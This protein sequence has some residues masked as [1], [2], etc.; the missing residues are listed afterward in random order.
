M[1]NHKIGLA[2]L[3][4]GLSLTSY[5]QKF[6]V[7]SPNKNI[8]LQVDNKDTGLQYQVNYKGKAIVL[9]SN[10]GVTILGHPVLSNNFEVLSSAKKNVNEQWKPVWG[11][12]AVIQDQHEEI[13]IQLRQKN[14][15]Q[16]QLNLIFRVFN[17][18]VA[19]R[20]EFPKQPNLNYFILQS[21]ET[22]FNLTGNHQAFWIPADFDTNE[23]LHNKT[24]LREVDATKA[25]LAT[26]EMFSQSGDDPTGVQTP[27]M[28]KTDDGIYLNIHEAALANYPALQ[29]HVETATNSLHARLVPDAVGNKAYLHAPAQS[30]WRTLLISDKATDI[31][32]ST[33]IL[34]LNEPSKIT[35]T[36]WIKPMKFVGVW[37]EYQTGKSTWN[38]ANTAN[39]RD[40]QGNLIPNGKHGANTENVKKYIDFASKNGIDGVLVEGWNYGWEDWF[41]NWKE[42]VFNFVKPYP[43]FDVVALQ[44]YAKSKGV[45][46]VMHHETSASVTNYERQLDTAYKFMNTYGYPAVKTGYVGK[47]IP[48]GEFHDGQWMVNHYER[49]LKKAAEHRVMVNSHESVRPTGLHRT[50]PNWLASESGRGNEYNAFSKGSPPEHETILPFTRFIGGPMDYTPG[51]FKLKGYFKDDL[52]RQ[53][54][55]TLSKQLALYVTIFSPFQMV[56]DEIDNYSL[57]PD[58]FQF[59]KDVAVDWSDT[60]YIE[61]E[62]GEYITVARKGK[63]TDN[64]FIGAITNEKGRSTSIVLDF[65]DKNKRYEATIYEDSK[66]SHWKNNPE[67]YQI[68]KVLVDHKTSLKQKLAPGG[69]VAISIVPIQK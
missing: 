51:I 16:L 60:R 17:D 46:M 48:R 4:L 33:T 18:A 9:P 13:S 34:N 55:T 2:V 47:I 56:A 52:E 21:E 36:D 7:Y 42:D 64:W 1:R 68:R 28:L 22:Q 23:Y 26:T 24:R 40:A 44:K 11:E 49:V 69:G 39:D 67:A 54:H 6:E 57:Y 66:D 35:Q 63:G 27:L 41:G 5:A 3:L 12:Y 45:Q 58:A 50:Y 62:P 43:D 59:I 19:F 10:L 53:V 14:E 65:L 29:L 61:A 32:A 31:L 37:W 20:Y 25:K 8:I 38:Y 30:P 15:Q